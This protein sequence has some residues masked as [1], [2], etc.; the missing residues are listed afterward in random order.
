MVKKFMDVLFRGVEILIA[1]FL[2]VM[3]VLVF[4]NVVL[5]YLFSF[6][7]VWSEEISRLCFIFL[8]YLGAI[9]AARENRHLMIDTL[10][11]RASKI[12]QIVIYALIQMCIV[13]LMVTLVRGSWGLVLMSINDKWVTTGFPSWLV[14]AAGLLTGASIAIISVSNL[15]QLLVKKVP[16][17]TLI[18]P[19]D[20]GDEPVGTE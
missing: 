3:I 19:P 16:V 15:Y 1:F 12:V 13:W 9:I 7:L 17:L 2:A 4:M 11:Y 6:G 5:R 20:S 18:Q 14:W 10:L 8:V